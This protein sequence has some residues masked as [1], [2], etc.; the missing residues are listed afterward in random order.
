MSWTT[1]RFPG[2]ADYPIFVS[3][4]HSTPPLHCVASAGLVLTILGIPARGDNSTDVHLARL[5]AGVKR[6]GLDVLDTSLANGSAD[7][8][9]YE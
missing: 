8:L 6:A 1:A 4:D 2:S 5:V 9:G 3:R 7:V